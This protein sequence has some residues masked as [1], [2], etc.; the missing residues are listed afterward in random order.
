MFFFF[1][2]LTSKKHPGPGDEIVINVYGD[3]LLQGD[4]CGLSQSNV[5]FNS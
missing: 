2:G 1:K 3:S 4:G 5:Q